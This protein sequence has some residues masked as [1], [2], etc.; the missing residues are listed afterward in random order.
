MIGTS[1]K[2]SAMNALH[3]E[4]AKRIENYEKP[5]RMALSK[6]YPFLKDGIMLVRHAARSIQNFFDPRIKHTKKEVFFNCVVVRHQSVLRRKLGDSNPKL[7]EQ[8]II[9][10]K[11]AIQRLNGVIIGPNDIFSLWNIVGKPTYED[12]YVDG[13]LLSNGKVI[14]GIGGGLCQLS[15]LLYWMF[16]HAPTETV[17]RHHHSMDVFP[18]SGRTLPFGSGATIFYNFVDLK[19]KNVSSHPL[20]LKIWLTDDHVK[21]QILSPHPVQEKIHVCEKNQFFIKREKQYFR[22]N[23]MYK[24]TKINGH[25]KSMEKITTNFAPVL[26]EVTHEYL[27]SNAFKVLDFSNVDIGT[28]V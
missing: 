3:R 18:D 12:G 10:L 24:E 26:Y 21:G 19:M 23:E 28:T 27:E 17:E 2:R 1:E 16:L 22:Y 25:V 14:E 7:Q 6:K 9:N 5:K 4:I 8:K 11:Q 13:M 15:N 20:Q